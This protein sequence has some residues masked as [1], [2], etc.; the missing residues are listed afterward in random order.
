MLDLFAALPPG[1]QQYLPS[2][3]YELFDLSQ[4][5]V[6]EI[7]SRQ[8]AE[9]LGV[10]LLILKFAHRW[11]TLAQHIPL[12]LG[13][14]SSQGVNIRE[15]MLLQALFTY[16]ENLLKMNRVKV[17]EFVA[18]V[19]EGSREAF[20]TLMREYGPAAVEW[21]QEGLREGQEKGRQEAMRILVEALMRNCPHWSDAE[22]AERLG[23]EEAFVR[24]VR[25]NLAD[26]TDAEAI[27]GGA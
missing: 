21:Q 6:R 13:F 22:P 2:F 26:R 25:Q 16:V 27:N 7:F 10:L 23:L 20:E 18:Q 5:P 9:Y 12:V 3:Q 17:A 15:A 4:V 24:Q 11:K 14:I 1:W 8:D 19:P